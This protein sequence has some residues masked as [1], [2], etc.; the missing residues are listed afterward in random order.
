[1]DKFEWLTSCDLQEKL[2]MRLFL[3]ATKYYIRNI[4]LRRWTKYY[5]DIQGRMDQDSDGISGQ[6]IAGLRA[7]SKK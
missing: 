1:M 2:Q 6:L 7:L 5:K 4:T 3:H